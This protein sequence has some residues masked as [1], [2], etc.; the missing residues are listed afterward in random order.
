VSASEPSLPPTKHTEPSVN[1]VPPQTPRKKGR[2]RLLILASLL[3][4]MTCSIYLWVNYL[5][6]H[7]PITDTL[8]VAAVA[9]EVIKPHYLFSI[10]GIAAPLGVAVSPDGNRIYATES[11]G[12]R[13][14]RVFDRS[15]KD[16][17]KFA[18]PNFNPA[19]GAPMSI[20]LD[21]K[22]RVFVSDALRHTIDIYDAG[23]NYKGG[24]P[25]PIKGGWLP[26]GLRFDGSNLLVVER[27][28]GQHRV[29]G[30]T[31][32]GKLLFQ[33]GK[34]GQN[35]GGDAFYYPD[36][37]IRDR[38]GRIYVSD[39]V[40]E[41]I[42]IF[43]KDGKFQYEIGGMSLPRGMAIDED[44]K[45]YVA[46][47]IGQTIGVF[48]VSGDKA[49]PLFT[50]GDFG[51]GDGQFNYPNDIALDRTGRLYIADRASDRVQVWAY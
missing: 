47:A 22:G 3:F 14:I 41:R 25:S 21:G 2:P 46:D 7:K 42:A 15:G 20:A 19:E 34:E 26:V 51:V 50:F 9:A 12:E 31:A 5:T 37:A 39:S 10:N 44:Q 17:A 28:E 32:A 6:T 40:N 33:F 29:L 13:M 11:A 1:A 16:L 48:D 30:L 35:Q 4:L 18:P 36:T 45:L 43:S 49:K 23:G 8:P 38:Q 24:V 27:T